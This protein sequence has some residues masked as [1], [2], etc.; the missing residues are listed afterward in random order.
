[1]E[2]KTAAMKTV[3][4]V[5]LFLMIAAIGESQVTDSSRREI[6]LQGVVNFRDVGGYPAK[7]GRH[8]KWGKIY[9]SADLSHLTPGGI[10]TL[11]QLAVAYI[12]DFRGPAEVKLAPDK[13][14]ASATR[15][16]L[17]AGSEHTGDSNYMKQM[18]LAARDSGLV[19]F[20]SDIHALGDRYK[21]LFEELL[22]ISADSA[23]LF[24]CTAGKDRTGIAAALIL[25]A[26][27]VYDKKIME[28]YLASNYYRKNENERSIKGMM[29]LYKMDEQTARNVMGVQA[30]YLMATFN[31]II[32]QYGSVDNYLEKVMGL[33]KTK[34]KLL[35][36]KF[37]E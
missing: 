16:S 32:V 5:M 8:V 34:R 2:V 13:I 37:L 19:P 1:M 36:E 10:D 4:S 3:L 23:V 26:L 35:Q 20:Y 21:P 28:D 27:N 24:H 22:Q 12:A 6:K 15:V 18:L 11:N 17:P 14:P 29:M 25:Y 31:T 9:R 33:S 7:D 30:N